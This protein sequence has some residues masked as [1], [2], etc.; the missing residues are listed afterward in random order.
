[1]ASIFRN[2]AKLSLKML[3]TNFKGYTED[4]GYLANDPQTGSVVVISN[5]DAASTSVLQDVN[6]ILE[7]AASLMQGTVVNKLCTY[8]MEVSN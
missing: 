7:G 8:T 2:E 3:D 6:D 1:M 4:I 5:T